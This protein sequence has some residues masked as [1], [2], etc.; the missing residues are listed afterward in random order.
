MP[1][2]KFQFR[3]LI[4]GKD[5]KRKT[6][7]ASPCRSEREALH[8]FKSFVSSGLYDVVLLERREVGPWRECNPN[9]I[10]KRGTRCPGKA[11]S[12]E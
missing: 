6:P 4:H 9:R 1:R 11:G 12:H 2:E 7:Q 8:A 3:I 5:W 10:G